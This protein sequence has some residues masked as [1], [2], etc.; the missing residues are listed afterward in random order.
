MDKVKSSLVVIC[1]WIC[2]VAIGAA[3]GYYL[4]GHYTTYSDK[5]RIVH[6]TETREIQHDT[7]PADYA[8]LL[9]WYN[10]Q[11]TINGQMSGNTL[12]VT[13]GDGHKAAEKGFK[14]DAEPPKNYIIGG[15]AAV[16][17]P[18]PVY[19]VWADYYRRIRGPVLFGGGVTV[20]IKSFEARIGAGYEW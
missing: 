12:M 18:S 11:I 20:T 14:L 19:G 6:E 13:A 3:G 5:I 7:A 8:D 16:F 4:R 2:S 1:A 10:N 9:S 15:V 17:N